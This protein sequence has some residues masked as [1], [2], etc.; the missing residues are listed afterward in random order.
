[1][2]ELQS[3]RQHWPSRVV[4]ALVLIYTFIGS[5]SECAAQGRAFDCL[6]EPRLKIKLAAPVAGVLREVPV[7]RGDTIH[8]GE[9]VAQLESSVEKAMFDLA[10]ARAETDAPLKAREARLGFLTKKRDRILELKA[11]AFVSPTAVDEAE[12][13]VGVATH[14]LR[15]A[16]ANIRIAE[17]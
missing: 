4:P 3:A 7:D 1:M 8:K 16:Q 12:S 6:I 10:Q 5:I 11:K 14:E 15:E 17:L 13:D 2:D 9:V